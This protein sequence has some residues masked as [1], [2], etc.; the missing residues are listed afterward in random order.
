MIR[1]QEFETLL[2]SSMDTVWPE[3]APHVDTAELKGVVREFGSRGLIGVNDGR[4]DQ[5]AMDHFPVDHGL[6]TASTT[7]REEIIVTSSGGQD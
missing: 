6:V 3:R 4:D 7:Q 5:E 2:Q 1:C